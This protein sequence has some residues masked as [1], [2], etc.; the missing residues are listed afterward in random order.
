MSHHQPR[1]PQASA[2]GVHQIHSTNKE[3]YGGTE[4]VLESKGMKLPSAK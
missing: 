2:V 4:E 3:P 1:I